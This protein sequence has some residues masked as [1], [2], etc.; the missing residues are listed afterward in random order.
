MGL[1]EIG[2]GSAAAKAGTSSK[3]SAAVGGSAAPNTPTGNGS[4]QQGGL[5]AIAVA[6]APVVEAKKEE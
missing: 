1:P 5:E 4:A 6:P 2:P 3:N